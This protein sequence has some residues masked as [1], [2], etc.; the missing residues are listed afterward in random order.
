[1]AS[2]ETAEGQVAVAPAIIG[3]P[4]RVAPRDVGPSSSGNKVARHGGRGAC[5]S[6]PMWGVSASP[7]TLRVEAGD[8]AGARPALRVP[9]GPLRGAWSCFGTAQVV[10]RPAGSAAVLG[11]WPRAWLREGREL[12]VAWCELLRWAGVGCLGAAANARAR[13]AASQPA[14]HPAPAPRHLTRRARPG[15]PDAARVTAPGGRSAPWV[16]V[17]QW[18]AT[19]RAAV[20]AAETGPLEGG[21]HAARGS[22]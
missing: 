17:Q 9:S 22:R 14:T 3:W 7:G 8:G 2:R 6:V 5:P 12:G 20:F 13:V 19:H 16:S 18:S 10:A 4:S 1:V 15:P 21:A 11:R